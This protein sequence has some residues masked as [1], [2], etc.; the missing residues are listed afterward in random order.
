MIFE[1]KVCESLRDIFSYLCVGQRFVMRII[2]SILFF[3]GTPSGRAGRKPQTS[4]QRFLGSNVKSANHD[5][6]IN[7][8]A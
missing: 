2:Y 4:L 3:F 5:F 7:A 6:M 8:N 1:E